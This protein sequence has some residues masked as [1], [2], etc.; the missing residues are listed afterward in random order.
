MSS[1]IIK[2]LGVRIDTVTRQKALTYIEKCLTSNR[3]YTIFTPNPEML[4][5]ATIN[6]FFHNALNTSSINI[7]DGIGIK[8]VARLYGNTLERIPGV[9]FML[10]ICRIAAKMQAR[11]YLLGSADTQV[12]HQTKQKL[13]N[14]FPG[15][16]IV[17]IHPGVSVQIKD[18]G[19]AMEGK[20]Y[21]NSSIEYS[22]K[23]NQSLLQEINTS[24][25]DILLVAFGQIKQECWIHENISQ[26][27]S[28]KIA[29]GVG[30]SF[31][32]ISGKVK[33]APR[34]VR[35]NGLEWL[36]RLFLQPWRAVRI[37]NATVRFLWLCLVKTE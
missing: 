16:Q 9:D 6:S 32:F 5:A 20:Q 35:E 28:V 12:L 36:W 34:W 25:P 18:S 21:T 10:S 30:G 1:E 4:V 22:L 14:Q 33:R 13:E 26:L 23:E 31:D 2:I 7:C 37:W 19:G 11:V 29:M 17:G 24:R 27:P 3:Q 8:V 15:L